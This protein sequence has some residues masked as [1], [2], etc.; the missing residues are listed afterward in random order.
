MSTV[1]LFAG[2]LMVSCSLNKTPEHVLTEQE[3][4]HMLTQIYL[5]EEKVGQAIPI[6]D[7]AKVV[8][9]SLEAKIFEREGTHDSI[10]KM[11]MEYY[12][13]QPAK[14]EHI[15]SALVDSLNLKVQSAPS[16]VLE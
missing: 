10:F 6:R 1:I 3:M 14:L 4:V 2:F 15:Y 13:T 7:S 9:K 16:P 5:A 11:S 8:F 12:L